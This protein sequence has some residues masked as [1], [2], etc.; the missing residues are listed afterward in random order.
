MREKHPDKSYSL[1]VIIVAMNEE[2]RIYKCLDS[3]E[4]I[5]DEIIIFDS[6]S[7]DRTVEI[8]KQYT[9]HVYV[10]EDWPGD[11]PQKQR[12]LEKTTGD[13]VLCID[14]DEALTKDLRDEIDTVLRKGP[15]EVGFKLQ[16]LAI[17]FGQKLYHGRSGRAP[18][19]L[20]K[21]QDAYFTPAYI[22]GKIQ[23]PS[24]KI[25]KLKGRL[26]HYTHRDFGHYLYKNRTYAWIGAQRRFADGK[27]G[28]GLTGA[29]LRA[30][31]TFILI[32]FFRLGF[33]DGRVGF[34]VAVMYSQSSFN[35]YAGLWT[36]RRMER[37]KAA[38]K[39]EY[40]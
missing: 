9:D 8:S 21:K 37:M 26:L 16:W 20:F 17:V 30:I 19:R 28:F 6:G 22:H 33:L 15:E 39:K 31:F 4:P 5:A 23:L 13:W 38:N 27:Q 18:L 36:L 35:K 25:R 40:Q 11:G 2:D 29:A 24:G 32:Y 34:L 3:V 7:N 12:A 10:T 14:A 1:S